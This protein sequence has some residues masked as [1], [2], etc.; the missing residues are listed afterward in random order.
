MKT[1]K[2]TNQ[3]KQT[4]EENTYA[5][6][7]GNIREHISKAVII[8]LSNILG[9]EMIISFSRQF[10]GNQPK[11]GYNLNVTKTSIQ[12][13]CDEQTHSINSSKSSESSKTS[14]TIKRQQRRTQTNIIF[15]SLSEYVQNKMKEIILMKHN[16]Q[17]T[18][19]F[20]LA[21]RR[22]T[23]KTE[24][25]NIFTAFEPF[26]ENGFELFG[27][28]VMENIVHSQEKYSENKLHWFVHL[29]ERNDMISSLFYELLMKNEFLT[30]NGFIIRDYFF[31]LNQ[32]E[33]NKQNIENEMNQSNQQQ[34]V[35]IQQYQ[36]VMIS[37]NYYLLPIIQYEPY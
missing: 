17:K 18:F 15:N 12:F 14:K 19:V 21:K 31:E 33:V 13:K 10:K 7:L 5:K 30:S 26:N 37:G 20:R 35:F 1:I 4:K 27:K 2:Q 32:C 16:T 9:I 6:Q 34:C 3:K 29:K 8:G 25:L 36:L 24:K 11:S 28:K 23:S 22:I